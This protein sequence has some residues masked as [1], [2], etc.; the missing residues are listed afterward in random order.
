VPFEL[1][2]QLSP[3][4]SAYTVLSLDRCWPLVCV[5]HGRSCHTGQSQPT[6]LP[7]HRTE[8][9]IRFLYRQLYLSRCLVCCFMVE[10]TFAPPVAPPHRSADELYN[11]SLNACIEGIQNFPVAK[12]RCSAGKCLCSYRISLLNTDGT[13][14]AL[15]S[16][17]RRLPSAQ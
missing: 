8:I 4:P 6:S 7:Q 10:Q 12:R 13:W 17:S 3:M 15:T 5:K 11:S 2:P 14:E 16:S 9:P 1:G